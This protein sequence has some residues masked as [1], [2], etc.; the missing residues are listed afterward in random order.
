MKK[1]EREKEEE[2]YG[3]SDGQSVIR[4]M[5]GHLLD[6]SRRAVA[7]KKSKKKERKK[8]SNNK[9]ADEESEGTLPSKCQIP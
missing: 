4:K 3:R 7:N 5:V 2:I 1:R 9:V 6:C 8:K